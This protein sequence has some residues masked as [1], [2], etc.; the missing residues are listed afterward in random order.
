VDGI[1]GGGA[2][3]RAV[4][5]KG[6]S[7]G[8][9]VCPAGQVPAPTE[10]KGYQL[11]ANGCGPQG[12]QVKETWG[13]YKCCNGHDI[14]YATCGTDYQYCERTFKSCMATVCK[15][16]KDN[17]RKECTSQA[18]SFSSMTAAF[19]GGFHSKSQKDAC[20][21][22]P[23]HEAAHQRRRVHLMDFYRRHKDTDA[24]EEKVTETLNKYKGREGDLYFKLTKKYAKSAI[25]WDN[26][27]DE[28]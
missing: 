12:L 4:G 17:Q 1:D 26:I 8:E 27:K 18:N 20:D 2:G 3:S 7:S 10:N 9:P 22:Y 14:C 21:C 16:Y 11:S 28:F 5:S 23:N 13:L 6:K 24:T 19:G 25:H 15:G